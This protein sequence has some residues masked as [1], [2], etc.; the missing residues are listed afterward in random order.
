MDRVLNRL[1]GKR[2]S[3][4]ASAIRERE[5]QAERRR[6]PEHEPDMSFE[7]EYKHE[8]KDE[9]VRN[10]RQPFQ[11]PFEGQPDPEVFQEVHLIS[12]YLLTMAATLLK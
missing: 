3:V 7:D 2:E 1:R 11:N 12:R 5:A 9:E 10:W 8:T 4:T 6:Q